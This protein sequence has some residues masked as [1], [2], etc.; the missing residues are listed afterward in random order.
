MVAEKLFALESAL[1]DA[2]QCA[3]E[4]SAILPAAR[5]RA[6]LSAC[7][8]Q[9]AF[10]CASTTMNALVT[11]R[12]SLVEAHYNLA[13]VHEQIGLKTFATGDLWKLAQIDDKSDSNVK[14]FRAA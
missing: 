12:A 4:L 11:A 7:V 3:G 14:E 10:T 13:D 9:D 5:K 1:D 8:G 2:L 6:K